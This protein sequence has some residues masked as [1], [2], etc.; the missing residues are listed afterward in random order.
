MT[1]LQ[2]EVA[3]YCEYWPPGEPH[4]CHQPADLVLVRP[5]GELLR[6]TCSAHLSV[7]ANLIQGEYFVLDCVE[8]ERKDGG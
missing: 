6:F 2:R 4:P 7:W 5:K 3:H 8:C 1:Q